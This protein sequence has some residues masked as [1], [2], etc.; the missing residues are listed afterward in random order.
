MT[1]QIRTPD[2]QNKLKE[3]REQSLAFPAIEARA[4]RPAARAAA[5]SASEAAGTKRPRVTRIAVA[6]PSANRPGILPQTV[7]EIAKQDR[8]PD[9]LI[10]SLATLDDIGDLVPAE[11]PFP[12]EI[13]LGQ[14]GATLQRN[15]VLEVV[16][17]DEIVL[18]IDDDFLMAPDYLR[19]TMEVFV[20]DPDIVLA[21]GTVLADGIHGAGY[22]HE[23]GARRL[24]SLITTPVDSSVSTAYSGYG[25]NMA[26]RSSTV[27]AQGLRFDEALPLYSW[28]EDV[29]FSRRLASYGRLVKA[30]T[31]RGVHMGSKTGRTPGVFLGYSQV[32]NPVY[33]MRKGSMTR[34]HATTIMLRNMTSNVLHSVK[35]PKWAD[36]R[37]RFRGNI[38]AL[39]DLARGRVSPGRITDLK[40]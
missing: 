23:E 34:K 29:D 22:N 14:K 19:R 39:I 33:L 38:L 40:P 36:F 24:A 27:L 28:L 6:I 37:G 12:V 20:R 35:P 13:V 30:G 9:R 25:C 11:L 15:R 18:F 32:A 26:L 17:P 5:K 10:L 8:L 1:D 21:T 31:M 3:L 16:R 4:P 7:R 2:L